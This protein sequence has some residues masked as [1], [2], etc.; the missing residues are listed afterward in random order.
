MRSRS[1]TIFLIAALAIGSMPLAALTDPDALT[2]MEGSTIK[3]AQLTGDYDMSRSM[4]TLSRTGMRFGLVATDLGSSFEHRGKLYF[5]FGD[6]WG[7]PGDR[8]VLAWTTAHSPDKISLDCRLASDGKWQPLTV[9][10]I[11]QGTFEVPTGGVSIGGKMIVVFTTDHSAEK[12]MGRSVVALSQDDGNTFRKLY[13]LSTN[14]F[15]NVSL[16]PTRDWLYIFGSGEY[17]KSSVYLAKIK[18]SALLGRSN[19]LYLSGVGANKKPGWSA[20]EEDAVP[21]FRHDVVGEFS[22]A[23]CEPIRRY[24]MLYNSAEPRGITMRSAET[25]WGPWSAGTIIFEPSRDNAYGHFMHM[26]KGSNRKGDTV[27]DLY[28]EDVWGGEYGPFIM[29]RFTR[30]TDGKCRLYYTMSTWNPYQ[31]VVMQ[32]DLELQPPHMPTGGQK[33]F[34]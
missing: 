18:S 25:P 19:L 30:G 17:R 8:D 4:P 32:S 14:K 11:S 7:R 21:L 20:H 12:T 24:V 3:V 16:W 1:I 5:L 23:Y 9:P 34:P 15:I 2:Y 31:V 29:S 22:V 10:G 13:D 6:S 26:P 27:S 33:E 28:R